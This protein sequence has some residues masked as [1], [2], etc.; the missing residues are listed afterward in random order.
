MSSVVVDTHIIIW[1]RLEPERLSAKAKRAISEADNHHN[2]VICEISLW[3][4]AMLIKK[5]RIVPDIPY[6]ELI[7]DLLDSRNYIL[8]GI[9][10]EIAL[11]ATEMSIDTKDPAD[12]LIAAT[13]IVLGVPLISADQFMRQSTETRTI[14]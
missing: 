13:S 5:K 6:T 2:L 8:Q 1:D 4:I 11:I 14:W 7:K 10:P 3:E 12:T 9:T